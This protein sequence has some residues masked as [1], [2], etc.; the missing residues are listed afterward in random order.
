MTKFKLLRQRDYPEFSGGAHV[1]TGSLEGNEGGRRGREDVIQKQRYSQEPR[2]AGGL[3]TLE[4]G[5]IL[6]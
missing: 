2:N 3:K 1:I 6:P 4:K 5:Q